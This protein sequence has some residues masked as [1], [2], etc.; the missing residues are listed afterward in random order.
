MAHHLKTSLAPGQFTHWVVSVPVLV[1]GHLTVTLEHIGGG[2]Q[3]MLLLRHGAV[4]RVENW[5]RRRF[6]MLRVE[7][8]VWDHEAFHRRE[9]QA[10]LRCAQ[11]MPGL[12][13]VGVGNYSE[14][15]AATVSLK[16]RLD[17]VLGRPRWI[18]DASELA[19]IRRSTLEVAAAHWASKEERGASAEARACVIRLER[20]LRK[21]S[22][23]PALA[24]WREAVVAILV[25]TVMTQATRTSALITARL[26]RRVLRT[27]VRSGA[28]TRLSLVWRRWR[29]AAWALRVTPRGTLGAATAANRAL[30]EVKR[31]EDEMRLVH[32]S[33]MAMLRRV[34]AQN[35]ARGREL[36]AQQAALQRVEPARLAAL[37][38]VLLAMPERQADSC[39]RCI[40]RWQLHAAWLRAAAPRLVRP[41]RGEMGRT[42]NARPRPSTASPARSVEQ[43][44]DG[45]G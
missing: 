7:A 19:L 12:W 1:Q 5:E 34:E 26:R 10:K 18:N 8:D 35:D 41:R 36:Q 44:V 39:A 3:P 15:E 31:R 17:G 4:P 14:T 23:A 27:L 20:L 45:E 37:L 42:T 6:S 40:R 33:H 25:Q 28:T 24:M 43:I 22:L 16:I 32:E 38:R 13:I 30:A 11:P 2:G 29:E 21:R 9:P